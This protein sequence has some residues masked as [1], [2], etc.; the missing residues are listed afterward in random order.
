MACL[1]ASSMHTC[2]FILHSQYL[3]VHMHLEGRMEV[4]MTICMA[5]MVCHE[6]LPFCHNIQASIMMIMT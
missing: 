4:C 3:Q 1:E 6:D 2:V 5:T